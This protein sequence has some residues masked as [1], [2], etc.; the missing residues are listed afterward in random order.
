MCNRT[1]CFI[2]E[3]HRAVPCD[4]LLKWGE[5]FGTVDRR[6]ANDVLPNKIEISTVFLGINLN[7]GR[8]PLLFETMVFGGTLDGEMERYPTWQ[9]AEEGHKKWLE[10]VKVAE[11]YTI[12]Q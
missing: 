4:D 6:V 12:T 11:G 5:W 8:I 1:G 3:G 7:L 2:L 10:K 9:D